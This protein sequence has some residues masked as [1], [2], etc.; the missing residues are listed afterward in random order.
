MITEPLIINNFINEEECNIIVDSIN[1]CSEEHLIINVGPRKSSLNDPNLKLVELVQKYLDKIKSICNIDTLYVAEYLVTLSH[2]GMDMEVH[3]DTE[4]KEHF[5]ISAVLYANN[6]FEGG[7]IFFPTINL[8][9]SPKMGDI[10]I[11][12]SGG[13]KSLHGV[14]KITSGKRYAMPIW[15]TDKIDKALFV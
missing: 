3:D 8:T 9:H 14:K 4:D 6:D 13:E 11:F 12:P 1:N 10:A 15:F 7:D 5:V 2:P